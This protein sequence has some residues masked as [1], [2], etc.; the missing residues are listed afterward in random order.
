MSRDECDEFRKSNGRE[1]IEHTHSASSQAPSSKVPIMHVAPNCQHVTCA[2]SA[3]STQIPCTT[4]LHL[5]TEQD[6]VIVGIFAVYPFHESARNAILLSQNISHS[7]T[8]L[9]L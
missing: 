7:L 2:I 5:P 6:K 8:N 4:T 9:G 3:H 1:P